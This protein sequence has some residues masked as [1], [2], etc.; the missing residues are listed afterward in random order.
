M[1]RTGENVIYKKCSFKEN[2][3]VVYRLALKGRKAN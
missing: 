2:V 1:D 3:E